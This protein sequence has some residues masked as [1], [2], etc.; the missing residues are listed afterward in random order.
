M[1][2]IFLSHSSRNN[3]S[4]VALRDWLAAQGWDDVFLDL[5]PERGIVAGD[6]WER[7]LNRAALRCEAVLFLVSRAWLES[8][9]CLKEFNLAHRLNKRLFGLLIEDIPVG[10]LPATLTGTWQLVPLA[11]GRDHVMLRAVLPGTHDEVH[12]TFSQE[13]LT[14]LRIGLE[15]AGLDARFFA[16]PPKNDPQRPPYRGLLP[17]EAADA[18]IFFGREAPTIEALD[19]IRG[20]KDGAAPRLLVLL[21][22]SGAGKSSFLRA[23]LLPRLTRD[24]R[25]YLTL[26]VI[27]PE[28]TA[29][30]GEAGLLRSL[31][32]AFAAYGMIMPRAEIRGAITGGATTLRSLLQTLIDRVRVALIADEAN[33]KP[34]ALVLAIDQGEELFLSDGASESAALLN[35]LQELL[36]VDA[37]ALLVVI[38]IRSDAYEQLQTTKA[39]EGISQ[40]TLS[41]TPMPRGA[42]Q[43]V[44]EGPAAR[45]KRTDR[46]L[47]IEPALTH[48]LLSDV[49]DGGGRDALPL[50]A[51]TLERLY[52]EYGGRGRLTLE[53]Y[54]ALGRIKGSIEAAVERAFVAADG[55]ARIPRDRDARLVLLRRGLIPW[56]AGI[57]PDT[58]S[59]RRQKAR[60]SE[61]P[62]EARPLIDL[63]VEQRLLSTDV[64]HDTG[65]R[66]IEPAHESLLRQWGSMQ[67]WLQED[68]VAL[69]NLETVKRAARDWAAND[70]GEDWLA[71][72][73][74]RL[75]EAE[76]LLQR[77]DL[78]GKLD[79]TDRTYLVVCRELEEA[80]RKEKAAAL[81]RRLRLQRR[82]TI[83]A[84]LAAL[85]MTAIGISAYR[86][87]IVADSARASAN[88]EKARA[89]QSA[90]DA[91]SQRDIAERETLQARKAE[92]SS[93]ERLQQILLDRSRFLTRNAQ[94][95]LRESNFDVAAALI[96]NALPVD[97]MRSDPGLWSPALD[98]LQTIF[99]RDALRAVLP[100]HNVLFSPDSRHVVTW[101]DSSRGKPGIAQLW[102]SPTGNLVAT[103]KGHTDR[104]DFSAS[105]F[106]PDGSRVLTSS[107]DKTAR[108]WDTSTGDTVAELKGHPTGVTSAQFSPDGKRIL[109]TSNQMVRLWDAT[110]FAILASTVVQGDVLR[111]KFTWDGPRVVVSTDHEKL[112]ILDGTNGV[113]LIE[114]KGQPD[115]LDS[116]AFSPD[117]RWIVAISKREARIWDAVKGSLKMEIP[118]VDSAAFDPDGNH[119]VTTDKG[120]AASVWDV[121]TGKKLFVLRGH[122]AAVRSASFSSDGRRILTTSDDQTV[123]AWDTRS[124]ES[125]AVMRGGVGQFAGFSEASFSPDGHWIAAGSRDD[126]VRIWDARNRILGPHGSAVSSANFSPDSKKV[127]TTASD[128]SIASVW[129]TSTGAIIA[130]LE[131]HEGQIRSAQ[132]SPDGK[133]IVTASDDKTARVWN[134]RTGEV[135]ASLRGHSDA[136]LEASFTPDGKQIVTTSNGETRFWDSHS[137]ESEKFIEGASSG[138]SPDGKLLMLFAS[139]T[140]EVNILDLLSGKRILLHDDRTFDTAR[141]SADGKKIIT[142]GAGVRIWNAITGASLAT[143]D[144]NNVNSAEF[145]PDGLQV[146]TTTELHG[147]E[148]SIWDAQSGHIVVKLVGHTASVNSAS[149]SPDGRWI[150]TASNDGTARLWEAQTGRIAAVLIGHESGLGGAKF[151]PDGRT[152]LTWSF[153]GTAQLWDVM[154]LT[155]G[156]A[157]ALVSLREVR[158]LSEDERTEYF[159]PSVDPRASRFGSEDDQ[160]SDCDHV[161]AHPKDPLKRALGVEFDAIQAGALALCRAAVAKDPED[162][163]AIYQLARAVEKVEP[164]MEVRELLESAAA[165]GYPA[166]HNNLG[167]LYYEGRFGLPRDAETAI[168]HYRIAFDGGFI[169]LA[170]VIASNYWDGERVPRD[171]K[172]A[173][174]W[175]Q[176]GA[177]A[178]SAQAHQRLAI[179][180]ERGEEV[181]MNLSRALY[182]WTLAAKLFQDAE[183]DHFEEE[184]SSEFARLRRIALARI[185][186]YQDVVKVAG[187]VARWVPTERK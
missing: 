32:G 142:S 77:T 91:R 151:S 33:A 89:D 59:P 146:A 99:Q 150:I 115:N 134:A 58:G 56:L 54:D 127:V 97:L 43:A 49:E 67:G 112:Q 152:I 173:I 12:V 136:V 78:A 64:A 184:G 123:R 124:G 159:L 42:H 179:L 34:P 109:T 26:P 180:Y 117:G 25:N 178:G 66:T 95:L 74:G 181:E 72:R 41:L 17:L 172:A 45:L 175:L 68:F 120:F 163:T 80:E 132:F 126:S 4:A 16:W 138:I 90:S 52:L 174:D 2:R 122:E 7:S 119:V 3:D 27:R 128:K 166:A 118:E 149:Y 141:F 69:T 101:S 29:I 65:E 185:L 53:D 153:D 83:A 104:L 154:P 164:S 61:I 131:G 37:P 79:T 96:K 13:G 165:K 70:K 139:S 88:I 161:A 148:V 15:R 24:D 85:A 81:E 103:L 57:D 21:G 47:T 48:A 176:R 50:L 105:A 102:G 23:G 121:S 5:D 177:S 76:R 106:S 51:F 155:V 22:A 133:Q 171:R 162:P 82:F 30:N 147:N 168:R 20:I 75:E 110:T 84:A 135:I 107:A 158:D 40:Q 86:E 60:I 93:A 36:A 156:D 28:R 1:S 145:S 6:R 31:E 44:I 170:N 144:R 113:T 63:L 140:V 10:D 157:L 87:K 182:H 71:H 143:L 160:I 100:G 116:L 35:V 169:S 92:Q 114:L 8:D 14:R 73:A 11:S 137:G 55:D 46:P 111:A 9:W 187:E 18:G 183:V 38:T 19:R 62:E 94:T 125:Q 108:V 98:V 129:D 130:T 186:P 167:S 39:L